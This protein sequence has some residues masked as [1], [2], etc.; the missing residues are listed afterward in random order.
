MHTDSAG[1]ADGPM[2]RLKWTGLSGSAGTYCAARWKD[3]RV[4]LARLTVRKRT[5]LNSG[6]TGQ[7]PLIGKATTQR[8]LWPGH[9]L[10]RPTLSTLVRALSKPREDDATLCTLSCLVTLDRCLTC[11]RRVGRAT[12]Y[13]LLDVHTLVQFV[14]VVPRQAFYLP[15]NQLSSVISCKKCDAIVPGE[16]N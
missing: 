10:Q 16:T 13:C 1:L 15:S 14:V 9:L 5:R 3:E 2:Q 6:R 8:H 12:V 7:G 4:Y 11:M